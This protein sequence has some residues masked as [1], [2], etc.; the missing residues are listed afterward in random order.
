[1]TTHATCTHPA[2]KAARAAC[3]AGT[4]IREDVH[5]PTVFQPEDYD[6]SH[7]GTFSSD[8][9]LADVRRED[10]AMM[11][12]LRGE[13]WVWADSH[14]SGKCDHCG[15]A[16][17]HYAVMRHEP[18]HKLIHI[19]ETCL[20]GRFE[21]ANA[22]F[23]SWRKL[24]VGK[25]ARDAKAERLAN[26]LAAHPELEALSFYAV[27]SP[28]WDGNG[29][30]DF[31]ISIA[32]RMWGKAELTEKQIDAAKRALARKAEREAKREA[33]AEALK[34]LAPLQPGRRT[35]TGEVIHTK[36]VDSHFGYGSS[37]SLKGLIRDADGYKFWGTLPT[38]WEG[39]KGDTITITATIEPKDGE[40]TFAFYKRPRLS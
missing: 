35:I 20:N 4:T 16:I 3:R 22:S 13:G 7:T 14:L 17:V 30:D 39:E 28:S 5:R 31:L 15:S 26:L 37:G 38:A 29:P 8:E 34:D 36:W 40:P 12:L 21:M 11:K 32:N 18:S 2:T 9:F 23:D 33:E 24:R 27:Q 19:G 1:M 6:F 25:A 10:A